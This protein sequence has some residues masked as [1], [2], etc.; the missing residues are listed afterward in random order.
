MQH[1]DFHVDWHDY[2]A[3]FT[4][5]RSHKKNA[6]SKSV[7]DGLAACFEQLEE[8]SYRGLIITGAD[9]I[10]SAGTDLAEAATLSMAQSQHK[11]DTV[12]ALFI[13]IYQSPITTVAAI[14]GIAY[15]GGLELAMACTF[16]VASADARLAL[17]EI[18]LAVLP[19]YGGSQFLPALVGRAK[20]TELI[21]TGRAVLVEEALQ[22]G[23]I[24]R[25][26][27]DDVVAEAFELMTTVT[28][29]SQ[30]AINLV[31]Q[32]IDAAQDLTLEQ[33]MAVEA[34]C[35]K[36]ALASSDAMEGVTAFLEKRVPNYQHR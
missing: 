30:V 23:L 26:C 21:L 4:I 33:G 29:H 35:A 32:C 1:Q 22:I 9:G 3:I 11:L 18:K 16:R 28:C 6:L 34:E 12:R 20:A 5:T 10:F 8:N 14:H 25:H 31:H 13:R 24:N 19:T 2:Y 15:G 36:V 27:A 17:P 7:I